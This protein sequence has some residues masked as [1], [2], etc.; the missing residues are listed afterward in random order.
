MGWPLRL[1]CLGIPG[2]FDNPKFTAAIDTVVRAANKHKKALGRLVPTVDQGHECNNLGL[3]SF[4]IP[5]MFGF[6]TMH[7]KMLLQR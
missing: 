1:K 5:V 6:F 2:E 3:I 4:V 7:W